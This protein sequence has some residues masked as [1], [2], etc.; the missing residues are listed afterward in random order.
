M[1]SIGRLWLNTE[2]G[3]LLY[4]GQRGFPL[5]YEPG[6]SEGLAFT[7]AG[8]V[9]EQ[10]KFYL[11]P[12][13]N[14]QHTLI[15]KV[16]GSIEQLHATPLPNS[17][18]RKLTPDTLPQF[19]FANMRGYRLGEMMQTFSYEDI[20]LFLINRDLLSAATLWH[21]A[22]TYI[23]R[24]PTPWSLSR[25]FQWQNTGIMLARDTTTSSFLNPS[26]SLIQV[27][28][29]QLQQLQDFGNNIIDAIPHQNS[30]LLLSTD[31]NG[32]Y[33]RQLNQGLQTISTHKISTKATSGTLLLGPEQT[34][35]GLTNDKT[36]FQLC[37]GKP[38]FAGL[39]PYLQPDNL[40]NNKGGW[41]YFKRLWIAAPEGGLQQLNITPEYLRLYHPLNSGLPTQATRVAKVF[42]DNTLIVATQNEGV[43]LLNKHNGRLIS[44]MTP[45]EG[46]SGWRD[47][48]V[49]N[50]DIWLSGIYGLWF[51]PAQGQWKQLEQIQG[52][53]LTFDESSIWRLTVKGVTHWDSAGQLINRY[54]HNLPARAAFIK[55]HSLVVSHHLGEAEF[56]RLTANNLTPELI[57]PDQRS[58]PYPFALTPY[59]NG[60]WHGSWGGGLSYYNEQLEL[61]FQLTTRHGLP[62]NI[63]FGI[64]TDEQQR[65]WLS[66]DQG[67]AVL[68]FCEQ[69]LNVA[70]LKQIDIIDDKQ[71]LLCNEFDSE[72]HY[73]A[74][75]G[76]LYF[77][78]QCGVVRITPSL[79]QSNAI[80]VSLYLSEL[81]QDGQHLPGLSPFNLPFNQAQLTLN[82]NSNIKLAFAGAPL[83]QLQQLRY[84]LNKTDWQLLSA[85]FELQFARLGY[86]E[87]LIQVQALD[88][89]H[90]PV[91]EL[92]QYTLL[93]LTPWY[94]THWA[95]LFY[96]LM[97]AGGLLALYRYR[98]RLLLKR[99]KELQQEVA[100]KTAELG[101]SNLA[102]HNNLQQHQQMVEY[103]SHELRTPL[104]LM[105]L[106]L[107]QLEPQLSGK[108]KTLLQQAEL[109]GQRLH[110]FIEQ[111]L[112][113]GQH[114]DFSKQ[115]RV[116]VE[117]PVIVQQLV[118]SYLPLAQAKQQHLQLAG[119]LS[120]QTG[121]WQRQS[122]D[123]ILS[124][125]LSN[126]I[127]H[128]PLGA[129]I[130]VSLSYQPQWLVMEVCDTGQGIAQDW[131][132]QIFEKHSRAN[133]RVTGNGLGLNI[134]KT[135]CQQQGGDIQ[136][137]PSAQGSC[138]EVRLPM[139][140]QLP[141][142]AKL[143]A[144]L[145]LKPT[146]NTGEQMAV[147]TPQSNGRQLLLLAEDEPE[148]RQQ[149]SRIL[150]A[151]FE[152]ISAAD[153]DSAWQ[154]L[155]QHLPDIVVSDVQMP[156]LSGIELCQLSKNS[157]STSHIPILLLSAWAGTEHQRTGLQ[158][159]ADDY[160]T[161]PV[162]TDLLLHKINNLLSTLQAQALKLQLAFHQTDAATSSTPPESQAAVMLDK[163]ER[164]LQQVR[165]HILAK[166]QAGQGAKLNSQQ[167]AALAN[168][169][170]KQLNRYCQ[171]RCQCSLAELINLTK[172]RQA[173]QLLGNMALNIAQVS[174]QAG[175]SSQAYFSKVFKAQYGKTPGEYRK[176]RDHG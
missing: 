149:L 57:T 101:N 45:Q 52:F 119:D 47:L 10:D 146:A 6:N 176:A 168:L 99:N 34:I 104:S 110:G 48:H 26:G 120:S 80:P 151:H 135:L 46:M 68:T 166:I 31:D 159:R 172:L 94:F 165:Q 35:W 126:A 85:P 113:L 167:L 157:D 81:Q 83:G 13:D 158:A 148:L 42:D 27:R 87:Q 30:L 108:Q 59:R 112:Q 161:K 55:D 41:D 43:Y 3:V 109:A 49:D 139:A 54:E 153:G 12:H 115:P 90:R 37:D 67:L 133:T 1:D 23:Q 164:I 116:F 102:L 5:R 29:N 128:C 56:Y 86:G 28:N 19:Y 73:K 8:A 132:Q 170:E 15:N 155:Q 145:D 138:F 162:Q 122:L 40:F 74:S 82:A 11:I 106:P 117:I 129:S 75:N 150:Q 147:K 22:E 152:V 134:V 62:S 96:L 79:Y 25:V 17:R 64:L 160:I 24:Q 66:T 50:G 2:N 131:Q 175:F 98:Q 84:R 91:S 125:L 141:G 124:N 174:E 32:L 114:T 76:D 4:D 51:K 93:V 20:D 173:K 154:L 89:N 60:V 137:L 61:Q 123:I 100:E 7:F 63:V 130:R 72:S 70:C 58:N 127:K 36:L 163:Q 103:L 88:A 16:D 97:L 38:R 143:A 65:V 169:S 118:Q 95:L 156:K 105:L 44:D 39:T 78:G 33:L 136:L 18:L 92:Y 69:E 77:G 140:E 21:Q 107:Q 9:L 71:G 53:S 111:L 142:N 171:Q 144:D 121:Y 14:V